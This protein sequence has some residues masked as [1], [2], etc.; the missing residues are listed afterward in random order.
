[1]RA[2]LFLVLFLPI[3]AWLQTL[4]YI[5]QDQGV[6]LLSAPDAN[7]EPLRRLMK[8]AVVEVLS[9]TPAGFLRVRSADGVEGWVVDSLLAYALTTAGMIGMPPAVAEITA[10]K[11]PAQGVA[12]LSAGPAPEDRLAAIEHDLKML[13]NMNERLRVHLDRQ[14]FLVGAGTLLAGIVIGLVIPKL[15]WRRKSWH[16]F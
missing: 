11:V 16:S 8:S 2:I 14:W 1:M 6:D 7:A 3:L 15:H 5:S 13:R 4:A 10:M 12:T 9:N